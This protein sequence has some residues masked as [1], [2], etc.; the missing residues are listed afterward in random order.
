MNAGHL[1]GEKI[2]VD[3]IVRCLVEGSSSLDVSAVVKRL[4][5]STQIEGAPSPKFRVSYCSSG[6]GLSKFDL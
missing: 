4:W 3:L 5:Y 2:K 6:S 1:L